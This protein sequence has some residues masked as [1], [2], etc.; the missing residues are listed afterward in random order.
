MKGRSKVRTE[1]DQRDRFYRLRGG[2]VAR[3]EDTSGSRF[4]RARAKYGLGALLVAA[5]IVLF[6]FPEPITST[7]GLI[8]IVVGALIWLGS[9]LR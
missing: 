4:E 6:L 1:D 9:W 8:L 7:A 5:G 3:T 2:S